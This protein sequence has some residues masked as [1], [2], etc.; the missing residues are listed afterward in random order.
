MGVNV[1]GLQEAWPMPFAFCTREKSPWLEFAED[2]IDGPSV[3][4]CC[5]YAKKH[6]MVIVCPI[7]ERDSVRPPSRSPSCSSGAKEACSCAST[8]AHTHVPPPFPS[9]Y[10]VCGQVN[11][12]TIWNTAVVVS[13]SGDV[14]G[15]HR[16]NH[17][18]RVGDFNE[19]TYYMEGNDGHP[20][21]QTAVWRL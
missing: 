15:K 14:L 2:A 13:N 21:F 1:L 7:L 11:Q 16:K 9:L 17:I 3:K 4:F 5:D 6:N 12:D 19:S 8:H 20:V 10:H 18:P